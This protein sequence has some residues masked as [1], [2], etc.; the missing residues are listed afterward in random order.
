M[1]LRCICQGSIR[2]LPV[3]KRFPVFHIMDSS[4]P[5]LGLHLL[6]LITYLMKQ[7]YRTL[8]IP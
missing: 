5:L 4:M 3:T 6:L 2:Y 1:H 7:V 8:Y